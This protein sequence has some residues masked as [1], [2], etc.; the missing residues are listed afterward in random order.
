[1]LK[2]FNKNINFNKNILYN[3]YIKIKF[4]FNLEKDTITHKRL[5]LNWNKIK[6]NG[7]HWG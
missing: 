2:I 3:I 7:P 5:V 1:M 4:K 6:I